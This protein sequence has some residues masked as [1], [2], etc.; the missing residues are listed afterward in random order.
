MSS[1]SRPQSNSLDLG[2]R[3]QALSLVEHGL[4][5]KEASKAS[6][7]SPQTISRLRKQARERGFD[8]SVSSIL[9]IEY[10]EDV[11]RSGRPTVRT[12]EVIQTI[13]DTVRANRNGREMPAAALALKALIS[14]TSAWRVL[15]SNGFSPCKRTMKPGLLP[16]MKE[17]RLQFCQRY[18]DWTL[19]D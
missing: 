15:R 9:K 14:T 6:G 4:S 19:E 5:P 7:V 16:S 18:K 10:V 8:P 13:L 11:K 2:Q 1:S 3:L 17:V 12:P